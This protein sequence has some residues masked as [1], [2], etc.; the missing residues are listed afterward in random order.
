M[1]RLPAL[2]EEL[3]ATIGDERVLAAL[4]AVDR[5]SFVP[6]SLRW[7]AYEDVALPLPGGQA[8][9]QP[10]VV[11]RMLEL[12][13][14]TGRER[15]LDVGTGSGYHAALLARLAGEVIS[16]ER[17]PALSATAVAALA[18]SGTTGVTCIVGDGWQGAP[19]GAPYDAINVAATPGP[20][21]LVEQLAPGGRLIA[22]LATG[23]PDHGQGPQ[24]LTRLRR[25]ADGTLPQLERFERVGFVPLVAPDR[26]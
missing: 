21:V 17:D 5:A 6:P 19:R 14:L 4:A 9:S 13:E 16:I 3:S 18:E 11:A 2:V 26:R 10:R 8:I 20:R 24:I 25:R 7:R 12:L 15:V 23:S 22:P 1:R